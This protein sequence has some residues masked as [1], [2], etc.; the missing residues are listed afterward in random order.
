MRNWKNYSAS[1]FQKELSKVNWKRFRFMNP[2]EKADFM[3]LEL[4]KA[5]QKIA[6]KKELNTTKR[7][8]V[9]V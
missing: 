7:N 6:L 9:G 8:I 4:L 3:E 2:Q 1:E 5:L